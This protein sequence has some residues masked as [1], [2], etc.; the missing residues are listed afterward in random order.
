MK[1]IKKTNKDP[2]TN[3]T[4]KL[5]LLIGVLFSLT[6]GIVGATIYLIGLLGIVVMISVLLVKLFLIPVSIYNL[7]LVIIVQKDVA[8]TKKLKSLC[9]GEIILLVLTIFFSFFEFLS[10]FNI[11]IP[12][13]TFLSVYFIFIIFSVLVFFGITN[14]IILIGNKQLNNGN[15]AK[16]KDL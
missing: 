16:K 4:I 9:I 13:V 15:I 6:T 7:F 8:Q 11:V 1:K 2:F 5:L 14:S 3:K 10:I 12:F